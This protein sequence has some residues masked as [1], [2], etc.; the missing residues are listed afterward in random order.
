MTTFKPTR[1]RPSRAVEDYIKQIY[2]L[3][4]RSEEHTSEL[5]SH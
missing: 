5:Q 3:M 1:T 4:Q 2:K